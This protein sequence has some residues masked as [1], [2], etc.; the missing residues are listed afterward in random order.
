MFNLSESKLSHDESNA[1]KG[2]LIILI[3]LGH[4]I[5]FVKLTDN[6]MVMVW[7]YLFHIQSFFLLPFLY[8]IKK[9]SFER[10]FNHIIRYY[11]PF[12][13]FGIILLS[14]QLFRGAKIPP[15]YQ[16]PIIFIGGGAI[17]LKSF[18]G[19]QFL[20]F[21]PAM[22]ICCIVREI[23]SLSSLIWEKFFVLLGIISI[24]CNLVWGSTFWGHHYLCYVN[25]AFRT[26]FWGVLL[27]KIINFKFLLPLA[28]CIFFAGSIAFFLHYRLYIKPFITGYPDS[29]FHR[30]LKIPM[31]ISFMLI[32]FHLRTF[33]IQFSLLKIIGKYSFY[34]YLFH[35][36]I[37]YLS[38]YVLTY[39]HIPLILGSIICMF[40]MFFISLLLVI[41]LQHLDFM[42]MIL[43]PNNILEYKNFISRILRNKD[44]NNVNI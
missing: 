9:I 28:I 15:L 26:L 29:Y 16:L 3:V 4:N 41:I 20:W 13:I 27:R 19:T 14:I 36:W 10:L 39:L 12:I 17:Y 33:L 31:S 22:F 5:P 11:V 23:Y 8:P 30:A 32:L 37:S 44:I 43:F 34:I 1:I 18:L 2:I 38:N 40:A 25:L 24:I 7:L 6:W 21:L 42:R 35:I